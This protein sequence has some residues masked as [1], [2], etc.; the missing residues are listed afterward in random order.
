[1]LSEYIYAKFY[2]NSVLD[3]LICINFVC[4]THTYTIFTQSYGYNFM[5]RLL[6]IRFNFVNH[7]YDITQYMRLSGMMVRC[8]FMRFIVVCFICKRKREI[9]KF[10]VSVSKRLSLY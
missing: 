9:Y 2:L 7:Y 10:C 1:M 5:L 3:F 4:H 6:F 8:Q